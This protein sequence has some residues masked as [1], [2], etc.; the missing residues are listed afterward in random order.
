MLLALALM[1]SSWGRLLNLAGVHPDLV[2]VAVI[3]W[4]LLRGSTE[5][6]IWAVV[7]GLCLDMLSSGPFG[8]AIVP[9]VLVSL[10]ARLGYSRV[11]GAHIVLPLFLVFPLSVLYYLSSILLLS[12]SG[13][14]TAWADTLVHTVLPASMQ[15]ILVMLVLFPLLRRA[16]RRSGPE[17]MRW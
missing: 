16:H 11:L 9:L 7:G 17:Q 2:L 13:R 14:P 12:L 1:E 6:L 10:C 3:S 8:L 5:G 15:N 4:T